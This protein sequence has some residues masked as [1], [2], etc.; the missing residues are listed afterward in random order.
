MKKVLLLAVLILFRIA[1]NAQLF[2]GLIDGAGLGSAN[3]VLNHFINKG[4]KI[5]KSEEHPNS[6]AIF[7]LGRLESENV[8]V[9]IHMKRIKNDTA[10]IGYITIYLPPSADYKKIYSNHKKR[11]IKNFD[12]PVQSYRDKCHWESGNK[13]RYTIGYEDQHVYHNIEY[14]K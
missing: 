14:I 5:T 1:V 4:Y 13:I 3:E 10:Q 2:T 8:D 6:K 7:M 9:L 11:F 12:R